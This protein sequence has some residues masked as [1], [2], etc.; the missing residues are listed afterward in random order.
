LV[1]IRK[2][3]KANILLLHQFL[4]K[5]SEFIINVLKNSILDKTGWFRTEEI[6][7]NLEMQ[8]IE[9]YLID[10]TSFY[11]EYLVRLEYFLQ[12][13]NVKIRLP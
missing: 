3:S 7:K 12:N 9:S 2:P 8:R 5:K 1:N 11:L 13:N 10:D 4:I 6:I